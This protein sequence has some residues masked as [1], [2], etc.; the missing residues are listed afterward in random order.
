M[1]QSFKCLSLK[2]IHLNL[3]NQHFTRVTQ[4]VTPR[5]TL[6]YCI[7]LSEMKHF[8]LVRLTIFKNKR[9]VRCVPLQVKVLLKIALRVV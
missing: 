4:H 3:K 8:T 2:K 1:I 7:F 6:L 5:I 9:C